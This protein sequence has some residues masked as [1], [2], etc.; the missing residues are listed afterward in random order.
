MLRLGLRPFQQICLNIHGCIFAVIHLF[1]S[2][3]N[4]SLAD[5]FYIS[6]YILFALGLDVPQMSQYDWGYLLAK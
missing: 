1:K 6:S 5:I 2:L 3:I 4:L